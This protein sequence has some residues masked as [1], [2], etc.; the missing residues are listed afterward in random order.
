M[1]YSFS[2]LRLFV[3]T[4]HTDLE[5]LNVKHLRIFKWLYFSHALV[6]G[7]GA[8]SFWPELIFVKTSQFLMPLLNVIADAKIVVRKRFG[9]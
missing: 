7:L 9:K 1:I 5:Q 8:C 3:T 6:C 4:F 2:S